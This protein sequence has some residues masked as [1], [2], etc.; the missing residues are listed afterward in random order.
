MYVAAPHEINTFLKQYRKLMFQPD[1]FEIQPR[2]FDGITNLGLNI[3]HAKQIIKGLK[4]FHYDLGPSPDHRGDGT[5]I[6]EFGHPFEDKLI[7]IK[8]KI[9]ANKLCKCLSFKE[10]TGPWSLP[11]KN[12]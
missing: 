6:W 10:S 8:L 1:N 12:W 3:P 7:Y 11:Y 4:Y 2:T 5:D 9:D